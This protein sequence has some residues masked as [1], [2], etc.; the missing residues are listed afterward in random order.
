MH[1]LIKLNHSHVRPFPKKNI[2]NCCILRVAV[3]SE[4]SYTKNKCPW[5][6]SWLFFST[7]F[8]IRFIKSP[9]VW[10]C[11]SVKCKL[12]IPHQQLRCYFQKIITWC[13]ELIRKNWKKKPKICFEMSPSKIE[14][15]SEE[16]KKVDVIN[17]FPHKIMLYRMFVC[18]VCGFVSVVWST[19]NGFLTWWCIIVVELR[20]MSAENEK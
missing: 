6:Y 9:L 20:R 16:H 2:W 11:S 15:N 4:N 3:A 5:M 8:S 18:A 19:Q 7:N 10:A 14:N 1:M 17:H 12:T 13:I